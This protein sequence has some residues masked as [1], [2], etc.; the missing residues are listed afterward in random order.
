MSIF[1]EIYLCNPISKH[2]YLA[3]HFITVLIGFHR[4]L[5]KVGLQT[6]SDQAV[7]TYLQNTHQVLGAVKVILSNL[8]EIRKTS[9]L[10]E[11]EMEA[12]LLFH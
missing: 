2:E 6:C 11:P 8:K 5:E 3:L 9:L 4:N 12:I 1:I 10:T 7:S